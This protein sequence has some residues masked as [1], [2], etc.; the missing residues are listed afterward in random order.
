MDSARVLHMD[1]TRRL[2]ASCAAELH[3]QLIHIATQNNSLEL[4]LIDKCSQGV[5]RC[6]IT[7]CYYFLNDQGTTDNIPDRVD[8]TRLVYKVSL[9][10]GS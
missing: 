7:I 6:L 8:L 2:T 1:P 10:I 9:K 3:W 4:S 5:F